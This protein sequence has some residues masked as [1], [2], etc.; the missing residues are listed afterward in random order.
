MVGLLP[1][2]ML[3]TDESW[4]RD[5]AGRT[6]LLRGVNLGGDSKVP[7]IP[8]G[9]THHS[10]G[11]FDHRMVSFVGR[12]FPLSDASEHLSRLKSWGLTTLRFLVTWEAI[13]H[14]GPGLYDTAYL[15]YIEQVVRLAGE[16]GFIVFIDPHQDVWSRFSGGDGAPGWTLEA[17]GFDMT[18]FAE[19][20][21]CIVH[22]THGDPFSYLVWPTNLGRLATATMFTL[23]FGGND[24]APHVLIEGEPVQEYLQRHYIDAV[25][26]VVQRLK[27]IPGLVGF[28]TFNEP[29]H[30][31]I[32]WKD[33]AAY[34][35]PL[36]ADLQPTALQSFALGDGLEQ[37]IGFWTMGLGAHLRGHRRM[38]EAHVRAW[39]DGMPCIWRKEGVWDTDVNGQAILLKPDYFTHVGGRAVNFAQDYLA[40]FL[41]R[42]TDAVRTTA[43]SALVF[44]EGEVESPPPILG[45]SY[46]GLVFPPHWYDIIPLLLKRMSRWLGY[47]LLRHRIVIGPWIIRRN[48]VSQLRFMREQGTQRLHGPTV[49]GEIGIK[50][51]LRGGRAFRTG[52]YSEQ[53]ELMNRSL[54]A[55]EGS[56]CSATIWNYTASNTNE[57]GDGWNGEDL[58]IWSADQGR[59]TRVLSKGG[60]A[61]RAIV[62]PYPIATA[63]EPIQLSFD[64]Y[65]RVLRYTFRHDPAVIEPTEI[66]VPPFQYPFGY[67]V[68]MTDGT[69]LKDDERHILKYR[70]TLGRPEHTIIIRPKEGPPAR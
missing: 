30:G 54:C 50:Y 57:R 20:C 40:P 19:T 42:Y 52:D 31:Y 49:I 65:R 64:M 43:P 63:G 21:A 68:W 44:V 13:E 33:L 1:G 6:L 56:L 27:G 22:Q 37:E 70:H 39:K 14:A 26:Q 16:M 67:S 32:G 18:K 66:F 9:A 4:L 45:D 34:D 51:D 59:D 41:R 3:H 55:V 46:A 62:R 53:E 48:F 38:N 47:D 36:R 24:F 5:D 29:S 35:S 28:E 61:L 8:D 12:P 17:V 58:S 15:D 69:F 11:F 2:M 23:F 7:T 10:D 60:R 25:N